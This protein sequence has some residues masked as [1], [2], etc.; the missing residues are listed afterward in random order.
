MSDTSLDS[1]R[2]SVIEQHSIDYIPHSERHGK[3]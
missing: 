1:N 2:E 3:V